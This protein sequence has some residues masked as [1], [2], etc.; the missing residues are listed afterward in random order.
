MIWR[1]ALR[2]SRAVTRSTPYYS[3]AQVTRGR[4]PWPPPKTSRLTLCTPPCPWL[5]K[6]SFFMTSTGRFTLAHFP[7]VQINCTR[8]PTKAG[9]LT[10]VSGS[11]LFCNFL[12]FYGFFCIVFFFI[13]RAPP[14]RAR[15]PGVVFWPFF[16]FSWIYLFVVLFF[17]LFVVF[18]TPQLRLGGWRL[19]RGHAFL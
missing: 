18:C 13:F 12:F 11:M 19:F 9:W 3:R 1:D 10:V 2:V 5:Q 4:I 7:L 14:L 8:S 16:I 17:F 6:A 15:L